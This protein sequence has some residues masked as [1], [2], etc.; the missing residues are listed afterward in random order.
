[1]NLSHVPVKIPVATDS[2]QDVVCAREN[3]IPYTRLMKARKRMR[4][5]TV[6]YTMARRMR[7]SEA[8]SNA[9]HSVCR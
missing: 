4:M 8:P 1:M 5:H 9:C 3:L 7:R 6:A 2:S